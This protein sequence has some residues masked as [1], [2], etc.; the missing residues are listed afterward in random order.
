MALYVWHLNNMLRAQYLSIAVAALAF[1][2]CTIPDAKADAFAKTPQEAAAKKTSSGPVCSDTGSFYWEIGDTEKILGSGS[3]TQ[4]LNMA[5]A[6]PGAEV[7]LAAGEASSWLMSA[8]LIEKIFRKQTSLTDNQILALT[9]RSGFRSG[10]SQSC[11]A[12]A[13]VRSCFGNLGGQDRNPPP[14][15]FHFGPG[16]MQKL[17]MNL[18][19]GDMTAEDIRYDML[20]AFAGTRSYN[21]YMGTTRLLDGLQI[22]AAGY[23]RFLRDTL[24]G[25]N[26]MSGLLGQHAVC[27]YQN[28]NCAGTTYSPAPNDKTW[29]FSLGHWVETDTTRGNGA[30]S[31][32]STDGYYVWIA[33][34]KSHYGIVAPVIKN[35]KVGAAAIDC[36]RALRTAYLTGITQTT[37]ERACDHSLCRDGNN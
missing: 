21:V 28:D 31:A 24:A 19:M 12:T 5:P 37:R 34:D 10:M 15:G 20:D 3:V 29:Q 8:Y 22:T 26:K 14:Y 4:R 18:D 16:H 27:A 11:K 35:S 25:K 36:G 23:A 13:K 1:V 7:R 17:G 33:A 30:F 2:F 9:M 32:F 6:N